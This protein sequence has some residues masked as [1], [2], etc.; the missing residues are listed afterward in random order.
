[1]WLR[2]GC[3]GLLVLLATPGH[4][5]SDAVGTWRKQVLARLEASKRFLPPGARGQHGTT[6][7]AFVLDRSGKLTS[8]ELAQSSGFAVLDAEALAMVDRASPFPVPPLQVTDEG[9]NLVLPV[10]FMGPSPQEIEI[11]KEEA[12]VNAK[13]RAICRGC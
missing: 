5:E 1:M 7:V 12:R 13:M 2:V 4:A 3:L 10:M 6:K 8:N 11:N 9:L